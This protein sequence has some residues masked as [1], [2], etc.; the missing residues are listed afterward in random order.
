MVVE[1]LQRFCDVR[2]K[3]CVRSFSEVEI[4]LGKIMLEEGTCQ[5]MKVRKEPF[6]LN[7]CPPRA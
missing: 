1:K 3:S 5:A 4:E 6:D 7:T 2:E